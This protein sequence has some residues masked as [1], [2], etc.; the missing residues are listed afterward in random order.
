[1]IESIRIQN[2]KALRDV[3]LKLTPIHVLIGKNDSGKT[4]ILEAIT[5]LCRSVDYPLADAFVG[6]WEGTDLVWRNSQQ[7]T[8]TIDCDFIHGGIAYHYH[9]STQFVPGRSCLTWREY[10]SD[11][12]S[13]EL[14]ATGNSETAIR[15]YVRKHRPPE[16]IPVRFMEATREVLSQVRTCRWSARML[17]LPVAFEGDGR[18]FEQSDSG[19]GLALS[20]DDILGDDRSRFMELEE[21][22]RR[23]FPQVKALKLVR[24][25]GYK[26]P[27]NDRENVPVLQ[28]GSGKGIRF[29]F[30]NGMLNVAASQVSDGLLIVLGYLATLF[31]PRPPRVLLVEEPENGIHPERLEEVIRLLREVIVRHPKTQVLLT[32]HSPYLVSHFAPEEVT[33]CHKDPDGSVS[34]HRLSDSEAVRRQSSIFTLGEIWTGE[35]DDDLAKS[36]AASTPTQETAP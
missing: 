27:P 21:H 16:S 7:D 14:T 32:T 18:P 15:R 12:T 29:D 20:L 9:L 30:D 4:S 1:M 10:V 19:F 5:A 33:L 6:R 28:P 2:Y 25:P 35:G 36:T 17:A 26:L 34:L 13:H 11:G 23:I 3:T 8:V 31:S 24:E 22:F